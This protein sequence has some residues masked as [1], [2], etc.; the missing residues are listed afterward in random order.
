M[1]VIT[2][3]N[4]TFIISCCKTILVFVL[5]HLVIAFLPVIHGIFWM[6]LKH[7]DE[8]NLLSANS[9]E[10]LAQIYQ[11][12]P[13]LKRT[14]RT[15]LNNSE[16]KVPLPNVSID[17]CI[18]H[19]VSAKRAVPNKWKKLVAS[20]KRKTSTTCSYIHWTDKTMREFIADHYPWFLQVYD[21]YWYEIQRVDAFRYFALYHFGGIYLDMDIGLQQNLDFFTRFQMI[22]PMTKPIGFSNDFIA[23]KKHH[24]FMKYLM[25]NLV[26]WNKWYLSPYFTVMFSTGPMFLS[27]QYGLAPSSITKNIFLL[28]QHLYSGDLYFF[29][30]GIG[31]SWHRPD[32]KIINLFLFVA[33]LIFFLLFKTYLPYLVLLV[34]LLH[35]H[36]STWLNACSNFYST[37]SS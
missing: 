19:Q 20:V 28:D 26:V 30:H 24:P 6:Q 34:F 25:D 36:R 32:T 37:L 23:A 17:P 7:F 15:K 10:T 3:A 16:N 11:I 31:N 9:Q 21:G 35:R 12:Y 33:G 2:K 8:K 18:V 5:F 27:I 22:L 1:N 29:K 4:R 13:N 14:N